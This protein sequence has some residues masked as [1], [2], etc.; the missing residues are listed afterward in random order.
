MHSNDGNSSAKLEASY[1]GPAVS[2]SQREWAASSP[3]ISCPHGHCR[4]SHLCYENVVYGGHRLRLSASRVFLQEHTILDNGIHRDRS[5]IG[6]RKNDGQGSGAR[7]T[8]F[9]ETESL[10]LECIGKV[11][12]MRLRYRIF[13]GQ[14][15]LLLLPILLSLIGCGTIRVSGAL[16]AS[17]TSV[18]T[19]TV[20]FIHFTAIFDNNSTL[21]NVTIVTLLVPPTT[22]TLT[23]CGNQTSQF[24]MNSAVQVS[25][26]PGQSC[27]DL[28]AVTPH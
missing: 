9:R 25:F 10:G 21:I 17:N 23:F 7:L 2:T 16:N 18:T 26:N 22:N 8:H 27:S 28:V 24:T 3:F 1:F 14:A 6:V 5:S 20:S 12:L 19:G 15:R 4:T 13:R 11:V